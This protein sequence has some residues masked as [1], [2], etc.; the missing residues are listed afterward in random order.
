MKQVFIII[1]LIS[2]LCQLGLSQTKR[3]SLWRVWNDNS[4]PDT[5]RLK[6]IQA[7]TWPM[8][9]M[10]L[11]S[12]KLLAQMQ[13]DFARE[14]NIPKWQGRGLYNL[15]VQSYLK[16]EYNSAKRYFE[17]SL[18]I[19]S[20]I[21]D[22]KGVAAIYGNLGLIYGA[23][24]NQMKELEYQ[25]K[26]ITIN[27]AIRDT[28]NLASNYSNIAGIY[29]NQQDSLKALD[30]Y[31]KALDMYEAI[32]KQNQIGILYNN[33]GNMYRRS[34]NYTK[35]LEYLNKS[36]DIRKQINDKLGTGITLLNMG[37]LYI[38]KKD[39]EQAK[40]LT[41]ESAQYFIA[42]SD[43]VSLANVYYNLGDIA[44]KQNKH[45]E[46]IENCKKA[47]DLSMQAGKIQ[48]QEAAC[49]CLYLANKN[50]SRYDDALFY[51]EQSAALKDSMN[52]DELRV[53]IER[54]EF[55][56]EILTDS[57]SRVQERTEL[58]NLHTIEIKKRSRINMILLG[59]GVALLLGGIL[60]LSRMLF[61]QKNTQRL[62]LK[63]QELEKQQL[64]NE[65]SLLKTQVNPHFLFNSLSILS[66]LV[67]IDA[68]KSE[69]FIDQLSK[70]YRYILEQKDHA[71][72]NLRTELNFI[73]SYIYLLH[74][75]FEDKLII[76]IEIPES[77]LD[78]F[79]IAPLTLQLLIENAVKHNKM[80]R[81]DPLVVR[82]FME[83]HVLVVNNNLQ[84]RSLEIP[85]TGVGLINIKDRYALLTDKKVVAGA[86][87]DSFEVSIPLLETDE[88]T[89]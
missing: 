72:V 85:S 34:G 76:K 25:L 5:S 27:E 59:V 36:L 55:E 33:M 6:A 63:T 48:L 44:E 57:I 71:L 53:E 58:Q 66:S 68:D 87:G 15:G 84:T 9:N 37:S 20:A 51:H 12:A 60:L 82:I 78:Q 83:D 89:I 23:Q 10:N 21:D 30:Y 35:A 43:N 49:I 88:N 69:K 70:S 45:T 28:D 86:K 41:E 42:V 11:D 22:K 1:I 2:G 32:G 7:I 13:Y 62:K 67:H 79:K 4:L 54:M 56:R 14:R 75:R 19:R 64:L 73:E 29:Q 31:L 16:G 24:G 47:L 74:V 81:T 61:F 18:E 26:S 65:I 39:F 50:L 17:Q 3:D 8:M 52:E 40:K 46:A 38:S 77:F 80:S